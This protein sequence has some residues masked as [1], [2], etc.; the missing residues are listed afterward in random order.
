MTVPRYCLTRKAAQDIRAI[1]RRGTELFGLRQ[2]ALYHQ[3]LETTFRLI[4]N[5]P[6]L[7]RLRTEINPPVRVHPHGSHLIVY[8]EQSD[9]SILIVRVHHGRE[10]W[11]SQ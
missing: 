10:N 7:A 6:R 8:L 9:G 11:R 1:Y 3:S 4:A 2:A 5:N